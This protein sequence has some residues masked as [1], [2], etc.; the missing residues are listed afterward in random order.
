MPASSLARRYG[1]SPRVRGTHV[2]EMV[3]GF[4]LRFIPAGAGNARFE[5]ILANRYA[6]HPRG[7]GE[8]RGCS[9]RMNGDGGSSPRVR[10]TLPEAVVCLPQLRFIPAGAGNAMAVS[11]PM[12]FLSVHPRGCGERS[13]EIR[14][15][16]KSYGSSPRVR[17]TL[18][19]DGKG[20]RIARFIPAGAG[21]AY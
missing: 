12:V 20:R 9:A 18:Y 1:S 5:K 8:R 7:C 17:G 6:V 10:G 15:F 13:T 2:F 4:L 11:V 19:T 14:E 3:Y 21:N 16:S